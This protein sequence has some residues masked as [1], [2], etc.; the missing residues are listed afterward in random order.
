MMENMLFQLQDFVDRCLPRL[1]PWWRR[2]V[3]KSIQR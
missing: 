1:D 3:R 2:Y